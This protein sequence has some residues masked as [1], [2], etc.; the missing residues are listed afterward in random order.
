MIFASG[1]PAIRAGKFR[2]YAE[3]A[4]R[5]LAELPPPAV[6]D[7]LDTENPATPS[8]ESTRAE[9]TPEVVVAEPAAP[10]V[11][12]AQPTGRKP[13]KS[14]RGEQL[15]FLRFTDEHSDGATET[16]DKGRLL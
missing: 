7:R 13:V 3:P 16:N 9:E 6:S 11:V 14:A 15:S 10:T 1:R 8:P 5:R 4:F 12:R 2:Y